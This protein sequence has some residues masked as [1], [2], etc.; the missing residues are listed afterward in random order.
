M[1]F[2]IPLSGE[3]YEE[4]SGPGFTESSPKSALVVNSTENRIE[5]S[6]CGHT[7]SFKPESR[8][9]YNAARARMSKHLR[10]ATVK[11]DEHRELHLEEFS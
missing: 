8:S 1:P 2:E 9:S 11:I 6:L 10:K 3:V 5:C 4:W 7:E